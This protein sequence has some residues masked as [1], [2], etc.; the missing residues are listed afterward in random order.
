MKYIFGPL[1]LII[2]A[3]L[4]YGFLIEPLLLVRRDVTIAS[5]HYKGPPLKILLL[6]D[7]HI[8]GPN[9]NAKRI[10]DIVIKT[11]QHGPYDAVLIAGDFINGHVPRVQRDAADRADIEQGIDYL[12]ALNG[13]LKIYA[14]LGNH[15][16]WYS[17]SV[18]TRTLNTA[19]IAVLDNDS[20]MMGRFCIVGI[21]DF[22]TD[23]PDIYAAQNCT[24]DAIKIVITHSPDALAFAPKNSALIVSGHTH[25]GQINLPFIGRRVT[26]TRAGQAYAYGLKSYR[27]SPVFITAGIGTSILPARFRAPPE[28][29]VITLRPAQD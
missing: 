4:L 15:D 20:V 7:F 24:S 12:G 19:G 6:S 22:D 2:L 10:Q 21:A 11:N 27:G 5:P 28:Y 8:G 9:I 17:K 18:V 13:G 1:A 23:R 3:C 16:T 29:V 25:G 26:S 14:S